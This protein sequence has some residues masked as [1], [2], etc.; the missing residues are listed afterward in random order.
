MRT[1]AA[2]AVRR[3]DRRVAAR[4]L[5]QQ[6]HQIEP[7]EHRA[8]RLDQARIAIEVVWRSRCRVDDIVDRQGAVPMQVFSDAC[9]MLAHDRMFH[10]LLDRAAAPAAAREL[11]IGMRRDQPAVRE[12]RLRTAGGRLR[13]R[14]ARSAT[15]QT[16]STASISARRFR[17][18]RVVLDDPGSPARGADRRLQD[19]REALRLPSTPWRWRRCASPVAAGRAR[20][21]SG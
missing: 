9:E 2:C 13:R 1:D 4:H 5:Q 16:H 14:P 18:L 10:A 12:H 21:G 6:F 8:H 11:A 7:R 17:K 3:C 20:S 15:R 19:H